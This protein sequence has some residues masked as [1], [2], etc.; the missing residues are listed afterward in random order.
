MEIQYAGEHLL[1]GKL[2]NLFILLAVIASLASSFMYFWSA[3]KEN[4]NLGKYN[5]FGRWLFIFQSLFVVL[6]AAVLYYII[7]NHYFEYSYVWQ[8]S[9]IDMSTK[10][11]ISCF[12]AGQDG[13][14]LIWIILQAI[15]GLILIK[16]SGKMENRVM[17]IYALAQF[18]L[19]TMVLGLEFF[20][21]KIGNSPFVLIRE[22]P[23]NIGDVFFKD[24][25][26]LQYITDGNGLNPLLENPWMVI[27]PPVLFLGYAAAL[28]PFCYAMASLWKKDYNIWIKASLPW[29]LFA[30]ISLGAGIMLGAAWAYES[31]T[32]GGFWAWDP[33]E[34]ASLVPWMILVAAL[35]F[36]LIVRTQ[37]H[38]H[39]GAYLFTALG[40]IFVLYSSFLTRSG[41]LGE[42]SVHSFGDNGLSFQLSFFIL[43]F[44]AISLFLLFKNK[45]NFP[46]KDKEHLLSKEFWIFL[47]SIII[48][49]SAFHITLT[50]SIPVINKLLG[51][52][53]APP[54]NPVAFYNKWQMPFAIVIALI[55]AVGQY[56]SYGKNNSKQLLNG[57]ML[58]FFVAIMIA[59]IP[60][61]FMGYKDLTMFAF[62]FFSLFAFTSALDFIFRYFRKIKNWGGFI[63][64]M[65]M[66]IFFAGI[67][68]AFSQSHVISKNNSGIDFGDAMSNQE[69]QLL[70]RHEIVKM[71]DYYVSYSNMKQKKNHYYYQLDFLKLASDSNYYLQF[72]IFP[73][74]NVNTR[75]GNV[76]NPDTKHFFSRDIYGYITHAELE[77][78]QGS[79][80]KINELNLA[81]GDSADLGKHRIILHNLEVLNSSG[82]SISMDVTISASFIVY[83]S[84]EDKDSIQLQYKVVNN[85]VMQGT[86]IIGNGE[87]KIAFE[88]LAQQPNT[89]I[90]GVYQP[91]ND[92][93]VVKV[94]IFPYMS[95]LWIGTIIIFAGFIIAWIRRFRINKR[96]EKIRN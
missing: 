51:T 50:T 54:I 74:I 73:S 80:N 18:F 52:N 23:Q 94:I 9:S 56:M 8:Y 60:F 5:Q 21:I 87:Q 29:V 83:E 76:Y 96:G 91:L 17:S 43:V 10:F 38:S 93:V 44:L 58:P 11:I 70:N 67:I 13:S 22:L 16:S 27:H 34:N 65:G 6:G 2:G 62:M 92:Y 84:G 28:A 81:L 4:E 48:L 1:P 68:L 35:H 37:K 77:N 90:L 14:F 71:G 45:K 36:I 47:G 31:L 78:Q 57:L 79:Y 72:S 69:N 64:H 41:I 49:L 3:R 63:S 55:M 89:I 86:K 88:G 85:E 82:D 7:F 25:N 40:F 95:I 19:I 61:L 39:F 59:V 15:I 53:M 26:Y 32:F 66:G 30:L 24:P 46:K 42:T 75:M 20:G 12:W 33:V